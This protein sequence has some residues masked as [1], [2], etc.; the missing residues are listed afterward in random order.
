MA[1]SALNC[2]VGK[3]PFIYLGLPVGGNP[4]RHSFWKLVIEKFRSKLVSRKGKLLL[5]GGRITLLTS[6]FS[7]LPLFYFS[8]LK[9]PK[10]ILKELIR[11]QKNFLWGTSDESKKIAWVNWERVCLAKNKGGL[12]NPNLAIKNIA[13]LGK[14]WD[15]FYDDA[16]NEKLWKKI[17]ISKYY[18]GTSIV[19][20]SNT[21]SSK[22]SAIWKD[23]LSIS[24]DCERNTKC[25]SEGFSRQLGDGYG[26]RFWKDA[27]VETSPLMLVFPRLFKL[28]LGEN[29]LVADLKPTK[30]EGW[31]LQWRRPPFGRELDELQ[32]LEDILQNVSIFVGKSDQF[33]WK[34]CPAG[35]TTKMAYLFLDMSPPCL[36]IFYCKLIWSHLIPTKVSVFSWRLLLNHLPTKDNLIQRGIDLA[37]RFGCVLCN[38][39]LEDANHI[40]AI[41]IYSQSIWSRICC[42][43]GF[44]LVFP[45]KALDLLT[46]LC[47]LPVP[48]D[49]KDC[50]VLSIF[51]TTWAIWYFRNGIA[52]NKLEWDEDN[53][54]ELVKTKTFAWI[55]GKL[56]PA[57]FCFSD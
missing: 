52:F 49:V 14:W 22:I 32:I 41:C 12:G 38:G 34:H 48:Q 5:I 3:T 55:K 16:E 8:I 19:S 13:L 25:F 10:G 56:K 27:W 50:W 51:T 23:I 42:W 24:R 40:F 30:G 15:K 53:L 28:T 57:A 4:H 33:I 7:A 1:A 2:K 44:S 29:L 20:I 31:I 43:W 26:T 18:S 36:D 39:Y 46:Q 11:I 35:Y 21:T 37:S 45:D 54:I 9:V 47:S 6:V 17:T